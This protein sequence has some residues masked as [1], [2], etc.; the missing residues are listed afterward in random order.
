MEDDFHVQKDA[1]S[2]SSLRDS[3]PEGEAAVVTGAFDFSGFADFDSFN[4][5][6]QPFSN[7][8]PA[9]ESVFAADFANFQVSPDPVPATQEAGFEATAPDLFAPVA[10]AAVDFEHCVEDDSW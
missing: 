2:T 9:S 3:A 1:P 5:A 10:M 7:E 4:D 8:G 6:T